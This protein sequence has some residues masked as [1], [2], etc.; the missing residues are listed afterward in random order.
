MPDTT[1]PV[2]SFAYHADGSI[3]ANVPPAMAEKL[4]AVN[5]AALLAAIVAAIPT[6]LPLIQALIAAISGST[7]APTPAPSP[8]PVPGK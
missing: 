3:T 2:Y 5:W 1:A 4:G 6:I 7:A 8:L